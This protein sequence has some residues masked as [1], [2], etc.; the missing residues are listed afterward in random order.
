[1]PDLAPPLE[2]AAEHVRAEASQREAELERRNAGEIYGSFWINKTEFALPV[3]V[4]QEVVN[5]PQSFTPVPLSPD[6]MVGLF[7]LRGSIIPVIDLRILLDY[8]ETSDKSGRKVAIFEHGAHCLGLLF[9]DTGGIIYSDTAARV[10]F[11]ANQNGVKDVVIEGMLKL[12]N[13]TRMVQVLDPHAVLKIERIP[14]VPKSKDANAKIKSD[15]GN[16]LN[17]ISFQ[18]GHTI[19][20]ID[21]RHVQEITDVPEMH[22]S[23][24]A[25]GYLL[26]NINLRGYTIPIVDFRGV[27]GN[28]TPF[29]FTQEMLNSRKLLILRLPEGQIGLVVYSIDSIISCFEK[30]VLQFAKFAIPRQDLVA[31]CLLNDAEDIVILLDHDKLMTDP[32]LVNAAKSCQEIYPPELK[33]PDEKDQDEDKRRKTFILFSVDRQFALDIE[34][35]SEVITRPTKLLS[36]PYSLNFVEG[37]LNL[38]GELITLINLRVLYGLPPRDGGGQKVLIFKRDGHKYGMVVDSVDE[39]YATTRGKV[40]DSPAITE[41]EFVRAVSSD[42]VGCLSVSPDQIEPVMILSVDRLIARCVELEQS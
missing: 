5:E 27:I 8:P 6:F 11:E 10:N 38:R 7:N 24:L 19:C 42:L 3:S 2:A 20:A 4:I 29:K 22:K 13:G 30:D 34:F 16:R 23:H 39:I 14:R 18:L 21:L 17:C 41:S 26:G 33:T 31:G 40:L 1:M 35:V 12:D 37:V 15:L 9:D 32:F 36:P 28:E 25:D